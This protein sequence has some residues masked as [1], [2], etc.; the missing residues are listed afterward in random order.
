MQV[1]ISLELTIFRMHKN[2]DGGVISQYFL[3]AWFILNFGHCEVIWSLKLPY[4]FYHG[5][6]SHS[7]HKKNIHFAFLLLTYIRGSKSSVQTRSSP[8]INITLGWN[9]FQRSIIF[10]H[11]LLPSLFWKWIKIMTLQCKLGN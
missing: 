4:W 7:L 2:A 8:I 1:E 11:F 6:S 3:T 9:H 5:F 10:I